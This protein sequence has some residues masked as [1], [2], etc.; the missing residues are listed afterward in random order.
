MTANTGA[1]PDAIEAPNAALR[2]GVKVMPWIPSWLKRLLAGGRTVSIDGNTLDARLQLL[3][4]LNQRSTRGG[5][6]VAED[7]GVARAQARG[8][9]GFLV[10]ATLAVPTT[11]LTIPGP[12]GPLRMR[13]YHRPSPGRLRYLSSST[14]VLLCW[15]TSNPTTDCA[16]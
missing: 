8:S 11:D 5:S 3:L 7:L 15:G 14:V 1:I 9:N 13:H 16:G 10:G 12:G 4:A 6:S 2:I